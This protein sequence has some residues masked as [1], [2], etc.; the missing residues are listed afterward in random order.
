S[1]KGTFLKIF[2]LPLEA[3]QTYTFEITPNLDEQWE[4]RQYRMR[5][6]D[7]EGK[8]LAS[9]LR[10]PGESTGP[11]PGRVTL[12][13]PAAGTYRLVVLPNGWTQRGF[14]LAVSPMK[15]AEK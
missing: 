9:N 2:L 4:D 14:N 3:G 1:G 5:I 6:E 10:K 12:T 11:I 7:G 15:D 13:A 8:T